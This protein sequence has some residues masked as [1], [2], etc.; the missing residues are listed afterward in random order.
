MK[1]SN[2][3]TSG[4]SKDTPNTSNIASAKLR[5]DD[6]VTS[7]STSCGFTPSKNESPLL[8]VTYESTA[9]APKSGTAHPR[10]ANVHRR[11]FDRS[12]GVMNDQISYSHTGLLTT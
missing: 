5:Y 6:T 12:A 9:P 7:A 8:R 10:N 3:T 4:N 2:T 1:F 11:S